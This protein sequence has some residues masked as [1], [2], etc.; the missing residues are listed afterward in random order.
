MMIPLL[1]VSLAHP[2]I[3]KSHVAQFYTAIIS[4]FFQSQWRHRTP[5]LDWIKQ[6]WGLFLWVFISFYYQWWSIISDIPKVLFSVVTAFS[7]L[8]FMV[9]SNLTLEPQPTGPESHLRSSKS[10]TPLLTYKC[11]WFSS[12]V[13]LS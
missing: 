8:T 1:R 2:K 5:Q 10:K 3:F 7:S 13:L 6:R 11:A 4:G 12:C 9:L